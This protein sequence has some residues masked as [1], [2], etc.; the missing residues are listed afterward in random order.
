MPCAGGAVSLS[1]APGA[2]DCC[3]EEPSTPIICCPILVKYSLHP[4]PASPSRRGAPTGLRSPTGCSC[5]HKSSVGT[6]QPSNLTEAGPLTLLHAGPLPA[7]PPSRP[8]LNADSRKFTLDP[9]CI[10]TKET[11]L[12]LH[13]N[14]T[15][16]PPPTSLPPPQ[17]SHLLM[18]ICSAGRTR[19]IPLYLQVVCG[20][21]PRLP[22]TSL[23]SNRA[24]IHRPQQRVGSQGRLNCCQF[25]SWAYLRLHLVFSCQR[26]QGLYVTTRLNQCCLLPHPPVPQFPV[27]LLRTPEHLPGFHRRCWR[28]VTCPYLIS[29]LLKMPGAIS[30]QREGQRDR[31]SESE[32]KQVSPFPL[33]C[34]RLWLWEGAAW[35]RQDC[36]GQDGEMV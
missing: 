32:Q 8:C 15:G 33:C 36:R 23:Y 34:L 14:S 5:F 19:L 27:L 6:G 20:G 18:A 22:L 28:I 29:V 26:S 3:L 16:C 9:T 21:K 24:V 11:A 31:E 2:P 25:S 30:P 4:R 10:S 13:L 12:L 35:G 1:W 7:A 17:S